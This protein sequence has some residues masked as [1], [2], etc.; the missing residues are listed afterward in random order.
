MDKRDVYVVST[1]H[2]NEVDDV[3]RCGED[4]PMKKPKMINQYNSFM[5]E[6]DKCDKLLSSYSTQRKTRKWWKKLF[7]R[8]VELTIMDSMVVYTIL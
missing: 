3:Q 7:V 8:P 4:V 2:G 6:I 1:I 5:N